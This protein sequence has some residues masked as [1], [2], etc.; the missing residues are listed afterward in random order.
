MVLSDDGLQSVGK[1]V[2][3]DEAIE[4]WPTEAWISQSDVTQKKRLQK[5]KWPQT[6]TKSKMDTYWQKT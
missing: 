2:K 3:V 1:K 6:Q 4:H 5:T